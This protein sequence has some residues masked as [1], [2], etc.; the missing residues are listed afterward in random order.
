[1]AVTETEHYP[2][3]EAHTK[4]EDNDKL[5]AERF[6]TCGGV[7]RIRAE[8]ID[9]ITYVKTFEDAHV[10]PGHSPTDKVTC[11]KNRE[12]KRYDGFVEAKRK[13]VIPA[14]E[15]YVPTNWDEKNIGVTN[16]DIAWVTPSE[17]EVAQ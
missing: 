16:E 14:D 1:M 13:G 3:Y 5:Y 9:I 17:E 6:C 12:Q 10:G 2:T 11:I 15:E 7:L 4:Y 8:Y